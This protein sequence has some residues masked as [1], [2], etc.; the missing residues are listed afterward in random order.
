MTDGAAAVLLASETWAR[1]RNL[2]VLAYLSYGK[3]AAVDYVEKKEGLLMAP[4][5]RSREC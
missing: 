5:T 4:A 3:A 1:E 2:P